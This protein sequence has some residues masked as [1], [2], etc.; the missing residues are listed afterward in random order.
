[1]NRLGPIVNY[2]GIE[3]L[4]SPDPGPSLLGLSESIFLATLRM[5]EFTLLWHRPTDQSALEIKMITGPNLP[6]SNTQTS[7]NR[8]S[9]LPSRFLSLLSASIESM[10]RILFKLALTLRR[11]LTS[12]NPANFVDLTPIKG[13]DEDHVYSD[14]LNYALSVPTVNNIALTGPFGAGKSSIIRTFES[15]NPGYQFLNISLA[16]FHDPEQ[17]TVREGREPKLAGV[18]QK[19]VEKSILQQMLYGANANELPYSRFKRIETPSHP[20]L[21]A[22]FV[23]VWTILVAGVWWLR[24]EIK[25]EDVASWAGAIVTGVLFGL[26]V[27][28]MADLY[29]A[30]FRLSLKKLSLKNAEIETA[31]VSGDSI[32]NRHLDEIIYFFQTTR[33]DVVVIE[34]LDRFGDPSIFVKLREIN[35][36]INTNAQT[37]RSV[38]FLYAIRDDMFTQENRAKFFDFVIPVIPV[39]NFSNSFEKFCQ[40]AKALQLAAPIDIDLIRSV[41]LQ[42]NDLRLINNL[43]NEFTI[44]QRRLDSPSLDSSKLFAMIVYKNVYPSDFEGLHYGKGCLFNVCAKRT[45]WIAKE[46][47]KR[48]TE[49]A[50][51]RERIDHSKEQH[52][53]SSK[54]LRALYLWHIVKGVRRVIHG[55]HINNE[56]K[57]LDEM[58][59]PDTFKLLQGQQNIQITTDHSHYSNQHS[60]FPINKSFKVIED[61]VNPHNGFDERLQALTDR[62]EETRKHFAAT[63]LKLEREIAEMPLLSL[64]ALLESQDSPIE[65]EGLA[66]PELLL[67]L[68]RDGYIDE[69]YFLYTSNFHEGSQT[70]Q[71][72]DF[73]LAIRNRADADPSRLVDTPRE[74]CSAMRHEDFRRPHVLNVSLFDYF[75]EDIVSHKQRL[76]SAMGFIA[77]NAEAAERFISTYCGSGKR[78]GELM[79][80]ICAGWEGFSAMAIDS[81]SSPLLISKMLIHAEKSDVIS[82]QN[83][84]GVLM[85][86]LSSH[87]S[88]IY[89]SDVPAPTNFS[90]LK[91]LD[92]QVCDLE[93]IAQNED[94]F[95]YCVDNSLFAMN[96]ANM[97]YAVTVL[98]SRA[99]VAVNPDNA[100]YTGVRLIAHEGLASAVLARLSE[101]VDEVLLKLP[102]NVAENPDAIV[103]LLSSGNL[104]DDQKVRIVGK[105]NHVFESFEEIPE[106]L[107]EIMISNGKVRINWPNL[108]DCVNSERVSSAACDAVISTEE[109]MHLLSK[110]ALS[111]SDMSDEDQGSMAEFLV[112]NDRIPDAAYSRLIK[113]V[114][115]EYDDFP[116]P[117][118]TAKRTALAREKNVVL[119]E[120]SFTTATGEP[121]VIATLVEQSFGKYVENKE[122]FAIDDAVRHLLL[123][124]EL[125]HEHKIE[126]CYDVTAQGLANQP[127]LQGLMANVLSQNNFDVARL[128]EEVLLA[129]IA[130]APDDDS[131]IAIFLPAVSVWSEDSVMK[132]LQLL[133]EPYADIANYGKRPKIKRTDLNEQLAKRLDKRGFV[134]SLTWLETAIQINTKRQEDSVHQ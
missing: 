3:I 134:S 62:S 64:A 76:D 71:D 50:F 114:D 117:L 59:H 75:L 86:H 32:F 125:H 58:L 74:V 127:E 55:L 109:H 7:V 129:V 133:P 41:S 116:A 92:V 2:Y 72:R 107:W 99:G 30:S 52:L 94:L 108:I 24:T 51:I 95:T 43:F 42:V 78:V 47:A 9:S 85:T 12:A 102:E 20:I 6:A 31:E 17:S 115:Y 66:G 53:K 110:T 105:Q 132:A 70:R 84:G 35:A 83:N 120:K 38:R 88:H 11:S 123:K 25:E 13:A 119:G 100:N 28:M 34:D 103:A 44:Y 26:P 5:I 65:L 67:S 82:K 63:I 93:S 69:N 98:A 89:S 130:G 80:W 111:A 37:K 15:E 81:P 121:E 18:D 16:A 21:K 33:Y 126:I 8:R 79:K 1:M 68:L 73:L 39:I 57:T 90:L 104:T 4:N 112:Q 61:E 87:T 77:E 10:G 60:N 22:M 46:T 97:V 128:S 19:L 36:L 122:E 27:V 101:Y 29:R 54:E 56:V 91:S 106:P 14:A 40:R 45:E 96:S 49:I 124:S 118:T 113:V 23:V 131:R 48:R